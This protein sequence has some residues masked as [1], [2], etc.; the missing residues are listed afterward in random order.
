MKTCSSN[1]SSAKPLS[2]DAAGQSL[3]LFCATAAARH[4]VCS[5]RHFA[6]SDLDKFVENYTWQTMRAWQCRPWKANLRITFKISD[7]CGIVLKERALSS[8]E[9]S[10][11]HLESCLFVPSWAKIPISDS[12]D[13][14]STTLLPVIPVTGSQIQEHKGPALCIQFCYCFAKLLYFRPGKC[15]FSCS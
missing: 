5:N 12:S 13:C 6:L 3:F 11:W 9:C 15:W 2:K 14:W 10:S 4:S 8:W 7:S 1:A